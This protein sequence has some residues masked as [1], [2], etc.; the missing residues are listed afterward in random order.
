ML[1]FRSAGTDGDGRPKLDSI[2]DSVRGAAV[3]LGA[4]C[5][6]AGPARFVEP[7]V[8]ERI[9]SLIVLLQLADENAAES[10]AERALH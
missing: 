6:C 9:C 4:S 8:A 3:S 1:G 7:H 2:V 5:C 10:D